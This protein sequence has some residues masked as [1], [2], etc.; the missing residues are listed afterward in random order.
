MAVEPERRPYA[1]TANV[2]AV[3][4]R[5][6]NRNLP[7]TIGGEFYRLANIGEAVF[8][9][10]TDALQFLGLIEAE[11]RPTDKLV[12]MAS[13]PE[14]EFKE[15]LAGTVRE[16]YADVFTRGVD[17]AEDTQVQIM[18]SFRRYQPKSQTDRMVMLFLG[19]CREAGIPVRDVPRDRKMATA[20]SGRAKSVPTRR[21]PT[22]SPRQGNV[23]DQ[24]SGKE[25]R[26]PA[27]ALF[28][29]VT[30]S[31]LAAVPD[32]EFEEFWAALGTVARKVAKL[33]AAAERR[34][35]APGAAI[36]PDEEGQEEQ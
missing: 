15:L 29:G 25:D 24:G 33:R 22:R 27:G 18:E 9:R 32:Q 30:E 8:G 14:E 19:L 7:Q 21:T 23:P 13:A 20:P 36:P 6:R 26:P 12:A 35:T 31:D 4:A 5:V 28:G 2:M 11:G 10:V 17:P 1:A 3:L 16:A 34:E